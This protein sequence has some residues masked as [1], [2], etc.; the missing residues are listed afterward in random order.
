MEN[1]YG[2]LS[3]DA[4]TRASKVSELAIFWSLVLTVILVVVAMIKGM[5][6]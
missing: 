5:S 2:K 3:R 1:D 6:A 4:M